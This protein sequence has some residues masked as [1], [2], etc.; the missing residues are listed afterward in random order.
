MDEKQV[1][2]G[3]SL[4]LDVLRFAAAATVYFSHAGQYPFVPKGAAGAGMALLQPYGAAAVTIFFV[5]S[6]YVIAYVVATRERDLRSYAVSR[7][8]R[9]YSVVIPAL[10]LTLVLDSWGSAIDPH[11]YAEHIVA[12]KPITASGYV[13]SFFLVNEFQVFGFHGIGPGSNG[14]W[15][16]LSFE[17]AYYLLAAI[18][19]FARPRAL[20]IVAGLILLLACG[21]TIAALAPLWALGFVLYHRR[22]A[23]GRALPFPW[24]M[25]ALSVAAIIA[26]P[27]LIPKSPEM[28]FGVH[29]PWARQELNRNLAEDYAVAAAVALHLVAASRLF[30]DLKGIGPRTVSAIRFLGAMTFPLYAMHRPAMFFLAAINPWSNTSPVGIAVVTL[31]IAAGAM[32]VTPLCDALKT[33]MRRWLLHAWPARAADVARAA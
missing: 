14:P 22:E 31:V 29:F 9:L 12:P 24:L 15:W 1:P 19:L 16:S 8:S 26:L 11:L 21:R 3:Y 2:L 4:Y 10:V 25:W 33:Q 20:A 7:I 30:R 6:G 18:A 5:L 17:A 23:L 28:N 32:L 27:Q 13:A